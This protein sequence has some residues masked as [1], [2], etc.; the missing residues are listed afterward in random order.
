MFSSCFEFE[1]ELS[2]SWRNTHQPSPNSVLN[3][4]YEDEILSDIEYFEGA[5]PADANL[6]G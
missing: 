5:G 6:I 4:P 2:S 3:P 1:P